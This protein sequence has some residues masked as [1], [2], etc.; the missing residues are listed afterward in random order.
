MRAAINYK[1]HNYIRPFHQERLKYFIRAI[2]TG[3][4]GG[5]TYAGCME[6]LECSGINKGVPNIYIEPTY[7]MIKDILEPELISI[8]DENSIPYVHNKSEHN[9]SLPLW[10]GHIWLR[11]GDKPEKLKG[12]NAGIIGIDEPFIQDESIFKIA[13]SRARHPDAKIKGIFLTGTPEQLNWGYELL[14]N[15]IKE[16][17]KMYKGTTADNVQYLGSDY[18][19]QLRTHY[20]EKEVLAYI[21]GE[22]VNLTT[23]TAYYAFSDENIIEKF[24]YMGYRPLEISCDFNIDLMCWNISQELN[25]KDFTFDFIE[26]EGQANTD[27]MCKMIKNKYPDHRGGFVFYGDISGGKRDPAS[28]I[29]SW[30]II[31]QNFPDA[32]IFY[33]NINNIKDRIESTNAMIRNSKGEIKY[34][35]TKNCKRLIKDFRQVTWELLTNKNKAGDLTHTSDGISYQEFWKHPMYGKSISRGAQII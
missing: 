32:K 28:S 29:S 21:Q 6:L 5:K 26:L 3:Y 33:Q 31:Q 1:P 12:I 18:I 10:D 34:Y 30:G 14:V 35:V 7:Q 8:L 13:L 4:G 15:E 27:L 25:G 23:G 9:F 2:V 22:F 11:S 19:E 17:T 16:N 24:D 20:S